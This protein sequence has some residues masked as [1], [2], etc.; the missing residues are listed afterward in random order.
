MFVSKN[1]N[2]SLTVLIALKKKLYKE[3]LSSTLRG[4]HMSANNNFIIFSLTERDHRLVSIK[5]NSNGAFT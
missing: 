1:V 5:P 2:F 4:K 3:A